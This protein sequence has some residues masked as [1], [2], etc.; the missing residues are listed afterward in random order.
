MFCFVWKVYVLGDGGTYEANGLLHQ[1]CLTV[2]TVVIQHLNANKL[3]LNFDYHVTFPDI[4]RASITCLSGIR[5]I[6][7]RYEPVQHRGKVPKSQRGP[8][9][10]KVPKS[11]VYSSVQILFCFFHKNTLLYACYRQLSCMIWGPIRGGP[12]I[13]YPL[14]CR[15]KYPIS[16]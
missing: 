5:M 1:T 8:C 6:P 14:K 12:Y 10:Q 4:G 11:L 15:P 7:L 2:D 13:P 3:T 16:R 9:F